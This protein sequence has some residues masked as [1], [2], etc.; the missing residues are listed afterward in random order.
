MAREQLC[1]AGCGR[2]FRRGLRSW[3]ISP[4]GDITS[5][6]V[7]KPC[8]IARSL[9]MVPTM[10]AAPCTNVDRCGHNATTCGTCLNDAVT[11]AVREALAPFAAYFYRLAKVAKADG[12]DGKAD[13]LD[14]AASI[15]MLGAGRLRLEPPPPEHVEAAV[16][17][18][19]PQARALADVEALSDALTPKKDKPNGS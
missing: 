9:R 18:L 13:G 5:R 8:A 4:K 12:Q 6:V 16:R 2:R 15:L 1:P 7:C 14:Q 19:P 3:V 17:R 11:S 10:L